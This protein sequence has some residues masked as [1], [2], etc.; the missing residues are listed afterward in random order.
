MF[1][2]V[3]ELLSYKETLHCYH[4]PSLCCCFVTDEYKMKEVEQVKYFSEGGEGDS[5]D[6]MV[7]LSFVP[8]YLFFKY[9]VITHLELIHPVLIKCKESFI[10]YSSNKVTVTFVICRKTMPCWVQVSSWIKLNQMAMER[11]CEYYLLALYL[12]CDLLVLCLTTG[13]HR[14]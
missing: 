10:Q 5:Q 1:V 8:S 6:C 9:F 7:C 4:H 12:F 3:L 11:S 13:N 2:P 14:L